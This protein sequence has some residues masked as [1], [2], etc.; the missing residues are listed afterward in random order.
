[1]LTP[2]DPYMPLPNEEIIS[3]VQKQVSL[4]I[5]SVFFFIVI[6]TATTDCCRLFTLLI[7]K[8]DLIWKLEVLKKIRNFL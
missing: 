8:Q 2:G 4:K 3:K 5:T 6:V 1:M 7:T